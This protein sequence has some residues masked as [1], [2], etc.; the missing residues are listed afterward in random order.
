MQNSFLTLFSEL[1]TRPKVNQFKT[2]IIIII[3]SQNCLSNSNRRLYVNSK[4]DTKI[5]MV[6]VL[7]NTR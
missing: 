3:N 1:R 6:D 2:I 7:E 4:D 5:I